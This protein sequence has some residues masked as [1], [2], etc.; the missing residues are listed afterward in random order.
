MPRNPCMLGRCDKTLYVKVGALQYRLVNKNR[1]VCGLRRLSCVT[2]SIGLA[3]PNLVNFFFGFFFRFFGSAGRPRPLDLDCAQTA[4]R[5]SLWGRNGCETRRLT[6]FQRRFF[7]FAFFCI[8]KFTFFFAA[9]ALKIERL[10][11]RRLF[12][13]RRRNFLDLSAGEPENPVFSGTP[14]GNCLSKGLNILG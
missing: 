2:R 10:R 7:L 13:R 3:T 6:T 1:P 8:V 14:I 11:R 5:K 12:W 9:F 4:C